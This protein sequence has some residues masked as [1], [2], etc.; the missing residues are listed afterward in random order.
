MQS[1]LLVLL[2]F[3]VQQVFA[4]NHIGLDGQKVD[5]LAI[6]PE[7]KTQCLLPNHKAPYSREQ[8]RLLEILKVLDTVPE[9]S[10]YLKKG[11]TKA[12]SA[13]CV[14]YEPTSDKGF[15]D[16][17][18]NVLAVRGTL[19]DA[20]AALVAVHELRHLD[21][22][23]RGYRRGITNTIDEE[24][25]KTYAM[26]ADAQAFATLF[27]WQMKE[28][29]DDSVW[30]ALKELDH[31]NLIAADFAESMNVENSLE[32]ATLAAFKKW[33]DIDWLTQGYYKGALMAYLDQQDRD[34]VRDNGTGVLAETYF[35]NLCQLPLTES[36]KYSCS[37]TEE[38]TRV[39]VLKK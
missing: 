10:E 8:K 21:Q 18:Y 19:S 13:L 34:R 31:Y 27:A 32:Q 36:A 23:L 5:L 11:Y 2:V 7:A 1:T 30:V 22:D 37:E 20:A 33:Y 3:A 6:M 17:D 39:P 26:E 35:D 16:T 29:G 12:K 15:F 4:L 38:I 25:R 14:N 24:I 28:N 9:T